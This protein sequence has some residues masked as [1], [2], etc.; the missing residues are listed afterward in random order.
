M[1]APSVAVG[2]ESLGPES[3]ASAAAAV[4]ALQEDLAKGAF[5]LLRPSGATRS[6]PARA[7][8]EKIESLTRQLEHSRKAE[9]TLKSENEK[10]KKDINE[11]KRK[12]ATLVKQIETWKA[13]SIADMY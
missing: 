13:N 3:G 2:V 11:L 9:A 1:R 10:Q 5:A 6:P 8:Q 4:T 7:A 12:N